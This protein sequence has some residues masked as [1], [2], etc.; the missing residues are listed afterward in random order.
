MSP[1]GPSDEA[2]RRLRRAVPS[3]KRVERARLTVDV[4]AALRRRAAHA[5]R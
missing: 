2:A 4:L 3:N 1:A 5:Q